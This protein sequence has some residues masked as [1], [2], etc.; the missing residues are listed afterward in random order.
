MGYLDGRVVLVSGGTGSIGAE[1]AIEVA[2]Q[3]AEAVVITGRNAARGSKTVARIKEA[4][5]PASFIPV[6]L[7]DTTS[8][9][10]S[11]RKTVESFGRV[12]CL[13]NAAGLTSRGTLLDTDA[14]TFDALISVNLKAPFFL[15]QEAI[16]DMT[17]RKSAGTIVNIISISAHGGQPYLTA[18]VAAKAGLAALTKNAANTYRW[19]HIR[20]NGIN[21][22]WTFTLAEDLV[23]Q[24]YHGRAPGWESDVASVLPMGRLCLPTDIA[25]IAALLL[26]DRSGIVTGSIIDWDQT[27]PGTIN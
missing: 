10:L 7:T 5:S 9:R 2:R 15:M 24:K 21:I 23:Q 16:E 27:V 13:I 1:C 25:P 12:D 17:R 20:V 22:G 14:D 11:V 19:N 26:S 6:E 8:A 3:G 4:G 18:Y